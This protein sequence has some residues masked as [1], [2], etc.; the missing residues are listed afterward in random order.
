MIV[1][2]VLPEQF[3]QSA[4][5]YRQAA[6]E[7]NRLA[8]LCHGAGLGFCFHAHGFEWLPLADGT[9]G[10][11]LLWSRT[12]PARVRAELDL[13]WLWHFGLSAV[14][15]LKELAGRTA[16][17]HVKDAAMKPQPRFVPVGQGDIDFRPALQYARALPQSPWLVVEQDECAGRSS[18]DA[19]RVSLQNLQ[20]LML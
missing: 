2:P 7:L 18:I 11:D 19:A 15:C 6:D 12:D 20:R 10:I 9:R 8:A 4:D 3:R 17:L 14:E 5:G 1:V 16:I 13:F